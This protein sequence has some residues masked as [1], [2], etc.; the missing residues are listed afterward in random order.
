MEQIDRL[1]DDIRLSSINNA[2]DILI[3]KSAL[4]TLNEDELQIVMLY[5]SGLKQKEISK[6]LD[7]PLSTILSKYNRSLYKMREFIETK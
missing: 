2:I 4:E 7:K 1:E 3:L 6:L 5:N